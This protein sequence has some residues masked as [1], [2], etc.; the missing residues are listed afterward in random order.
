MHRSD[1]R[2]QAA[3]SVAAESIYNSVLPYPRARSCSCSQLA[4]A[5]LRALPVLDADA[6]RA[7]CVIIRL[8]PE[9]ADADGEALR[10]D[11]ALPAQR[12]PP[13]EAVAAPARAAQEAHV[14]VPLAGAAGVVACVVRVAAAT[15][16]EVGNP[17]APV[18]RARPAVR[19]EVVAGG[20][21]EALLPT[22]GESEPDA[23]RGEGGGA[24]VELSEGLT[25]CEADGSWGAGAAKAKTSA[26]RKTSR[27]WPK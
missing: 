12:V 27:R 18:R 13:L 1:D 4:A 9:H 25:L 23:L 3:S 26:Q 14:A 17:R 15:E 20:H 5:E 19:R 10:P 24:G 21:F 11:R 8:L 7:L 2:Q 6:A 22:V 16:P